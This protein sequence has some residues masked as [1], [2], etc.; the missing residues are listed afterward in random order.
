M[1]KLE[2]CDCY[3]LM[4]PIKIAN[5]SAVWRTAVATFSREWCDDPSVD[6]E[7]EAGMLVKPKGNALKFGLVATGCDLIKITQ[8][9]TKL[10][11]VKAFREEH[12]HHCSAVPTIQLIE[13]WTPYV[14][15]RKPWSFF[16]TP[17]TITWFEIAL[18]QEKV[19]VYNWKQLVDED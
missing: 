12:L 18:P 6:R 13:S 5:L 17:K 4:L 11:F 7:A 3:S 8:N 16:L 19:G 9:A 10:C 1:G 14:Q 2:H 15:I